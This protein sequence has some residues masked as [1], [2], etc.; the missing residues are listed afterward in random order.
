MPSSNFR[1][2]L[3]LVIIV[4]VVLLIPAAL[5][6]FNTMRSQGMAKYFAT[7]TPPPV[8]VETTT[9]Q[10]VAVPQELTGIGTIQAVHQVTVAPEVGGRVVA[11]LFQSGAH[12]AAQAPLVQLN[13]APDLGDLANYRAQALN[14]QVNLQRAQKLVGR[15]FET[16]VNVDLN[17]AQLDEAQGLIAKTEAQIAQKLIRAPF[18][19][20]LGI[21]QIDLGQYLNPGGAVVTL[22]D[23]DTLYLN[24]SL[25]E[26]NLDKL[27][28]GQTVDVTVDA[29]P[30]RIFKADL[31]AIE[32][33]I[34]TDTRAI[35]L[36]ATLP[37]PGHL[38]LPGMSA[39]AAVELPPLA[40]QVTLPE[41]SV[42]FS[43]YGDAVFLIDNEGTDNLGKPILK[44]KRQFVQTGEHFDGN[45]AIVH[46]L[47]AGAVVALSGQLKLS[48]GATVSIVPGVT[49][50][51]PATLPNE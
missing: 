12:I 1:V 25:P 44:A 13:D 9:A 45:V 26:Q 16:Q 51:P 22:T 6:G 17:K 29:Y 34:S 37:N 21:R 33:Q 18:D 49:L 47:N 43:L 15:Q 19:G 32:P 8:A 3:V 39:N 24:F 46:G 20:E 42:E 31:T 30:G 14:A 48:D 35:S 28:L 7:M 40:A 2:R 38:L 27:K 23:L 50:Q 4:V 41:T 11:I 10:L 5:V 36:Q